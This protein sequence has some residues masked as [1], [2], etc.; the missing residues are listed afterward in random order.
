[1]PAQAELYRVVEAKLQAVIGE[2][3]RVTTV[4]R[5]ALLVSGLVAA[6]SSVVS[7]MAAGLWEAGVSMAQVTSIARRLRRSLHD[8]KVTAATCYEPAV[9][10]LIDWEGL[11]RR[12]KPAILALDES[13]QDERV[14]L[15]RVSLTYWG[16]AVPLAW[17]VWPQNVAMDEGEYW[18]RIDAVLDRVTAL[19]P[20]GL[21]VILTADRA[22]DIPPFVA[23]VAARGWHWVVRLKAEGANRFLDW[24]GR[25]HGLK[26]L[27]HRHVAAPGQRWKARGRIFKGAGW[28][29]AS[30]VAV[31]APGAKERLVV[32]TDLP[33]TWEVLRHYD[34]RFWIESGFRTDK[35]QGWHWEACQV[36][37]LEHHA[38]LLVAMAWATLLVLCLGLAEARAALATVATRRASPPTTHRSPPK[39]QHAR[40]SLFTLGL[41][42]ARRWLARTA[43]PRFLWFLSQLS[44]PAWTTRWY[45]AQAYRYLFSQTVRP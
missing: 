38:R 1:M 3:V 9:R 36:T 6:K 5:L 2:R 10:T 42:L 22:F 13:S 29:P 43:V 44:A 20:A 8:P 45:R 40:A 25:E 4:R 34:R 30:V 35:T 24:Q 27:A 32:I 33:P 23:R 7:Q 16:T 37:D 12:G 31:W 18:R 39:P 26:T 28:R 17:E 15:L 11:A 19:L 14:H 41:R 21:T